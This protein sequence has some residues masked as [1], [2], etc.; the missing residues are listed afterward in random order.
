[1]NDRPDTFEGEPAYVQDFWDRAKNGGAEV[2]ETVYKFTITKEDSEKYPE[3]KPG[4]RLLLA[5]SPDGFVFHDL[6]P[7]RLTN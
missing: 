5:K 6:L 2:D 7:P 3:L 1:M 4:M